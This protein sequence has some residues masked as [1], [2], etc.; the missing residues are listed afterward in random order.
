[1]ADGL[2]TPRTD[3][4]VSHI[5]IPVCPCPPWHPLCKY[6]QRLGVGPPC[7]LGQR[8][9]WNFASEAPLNEQQSSG[10]PSIPTHQS[11]SISSSPIDIQS[12]YVNGPYKLETPFHNVC[13][14]AKPVG[15]RASLNDPLHLKLA[16]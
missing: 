12:V 13:H 6:Q 11:Y 9:R 16:G 2:S 4:V 3:A 14:Y 5:D 15:H 7:R 1:M 10:P 8:W